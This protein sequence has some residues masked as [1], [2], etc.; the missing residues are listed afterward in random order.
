M[1]MLSEVGTDKATSDPEFT[2]ASTSNGN[3]KHLKRPIN[4]VE[5]DDPETPLPTPSQ[6]PAKRTRSSTKTPDTKDK[7]PD[8][9]GKTPDTKGKTLDKKGKLTIKLLSTRRYGYV[10]MLENGDRLPSLVRFDANAL[11]F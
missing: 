5:D 3:A 2:E 4:D 10:A 8:K 11:E 6:S 7:T 9:K 1:Q